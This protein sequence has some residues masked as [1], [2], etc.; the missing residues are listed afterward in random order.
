MRTFEGLTQNNQASQSIEVHVQ[1]KG[2][3]TIQISADRTRTM[4]KKTSTYNE[5]FSKQRN[6]WYWGL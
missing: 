5:I 2:I 4:N 3:K 6:D 1:E